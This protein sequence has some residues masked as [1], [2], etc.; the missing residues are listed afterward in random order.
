MDP[1]MQ[2]L[3]SM[4]L[5][6]EPHG[7]RPEQ[8]EEACLDMSGAF[9]KGLSEEF[10]EASLTFD[11]FHLM[12]LLNKA[13]DELRRQ[14]QA[15]HPTVLPRFFP[16]L[17]PRNLVSQTFGH[18]GSTTGHR[19]STTPGVRPEAPRTVCCGRNW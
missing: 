1:Q 10:P 8:I 12:Q 3:F 4:A 13:V 5:D 15:T 6:L 14:E 19:G 11:N 16:I 2:Q 9:T 7:G 17:F 18:R